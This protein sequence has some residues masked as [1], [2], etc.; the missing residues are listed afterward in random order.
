MG[1]ATGLHHAV[2]CSE[3]LG[4]HAPE[5]PPEERAAAQDGS[6]LFASAFR[7]LYQRACTGWPRAAVP[8]AFYRVAPSPVP[9][10]LL[11]GGAD[12]VTPPRHAERTAAALGAQ[13]RHIVM[14]QAG[15]GVLSQ[16]CVRDAV[17]GFITLD[18]DAAALAAEREALAS[19][20]QRLPR[21][22]AFVPPGLSTVQPVQEAR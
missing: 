17:R 6:N 7:H 4:D 5:P 19:C 9:V 22:P 20:G 16:P 10:W 11:S 3:D 2:V 15:H 12:P 21:P 8:A 1:I 13:A 14:A 18:D